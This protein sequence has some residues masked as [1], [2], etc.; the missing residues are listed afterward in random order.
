MGLKPIPVKHITV[1]KTPVKYMIF[2]SN[3][4]FPLL[5]VRSIAKDSS[6]TG[7]N[8]R[9]GLNILDDRLAAS[10]DWAPLII[11]RSSC[12]RETHIKKA[13]AAILSLLPG[14]FKKVMAP[15]MKI[16]VKDTI[17]DRKSTRLNSSHANISYAG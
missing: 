6:V 1:P 2:S 8:I 15:N 3:S 11:K 4:I 16:P 9:A 7:T 12:H 14:D 10:S 17:V 5:L 13:A